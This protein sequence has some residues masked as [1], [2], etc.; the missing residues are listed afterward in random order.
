MRGAIAVAAALSVA[1]VG[2]SALTTRA[3]GAYP[4][5]VTPDPAGV[6][7]RAAGVSTQAPVATGAG[8][9]PQTPAAG[10][11]VSPGAAHSA[12]VDDQASSPCGSVVLP[13]S[14]WLGGDGVDVFSNG[15]DAARA[16]VAAGSRQSAAS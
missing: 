3:A 16:R 1:L 14:A 7:P 13:G 5:G 8:V 9:T 4:A 12:G 6:T 11:S 15:A 2:G 10:T